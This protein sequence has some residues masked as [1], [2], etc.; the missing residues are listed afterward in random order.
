MS[1][2]FELHYDL[3][4]IVDGLITCETCRRDA[5]GFSFSGSRRVVSGSLNRAVVSL[6]K[7]LKM[8]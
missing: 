4:E 6:R 7:L 3:S 8:H 1:F 5:E 2:G